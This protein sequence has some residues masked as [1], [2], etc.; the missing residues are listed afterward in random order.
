MQRQKLV[1]GYYVTVKWNSLIA[2]YDRERLTNITIAE[3][4]DIASTYRVSTI[5]YFMSE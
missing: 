4:T 3:S 1:N 2:I 5:R